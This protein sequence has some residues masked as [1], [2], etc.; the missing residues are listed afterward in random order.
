V[1]LIVESKE[2]EVEI[3][4]CILGG[5]RVHVDAELT[6]RNSIIDA[7]EDGI[8]YADDDGAG[9]GGE[10]RL[11]ECTVLGRVHA[12]TIQ[13]VSNSI[14][15][16]RVPEDETAQWPGPVLA[17]RKQAGCI[18]FSWLPAGSRTPRRHRCQP[19]RDADAAWL[20]PVL[21]SSR[22][23]DPGYCQLDR[24]TPGEIRRGADDEAEM[25]V[26]HDLYQPQREDYLSV[27][28]EEYLRFGLESGIFFET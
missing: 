12:R 6:A 5:L 8:A 17:D 4:S 22:Y 3:E 7:G 16:A 26:F 23:A 2:T 24:R 15:L 21:T 9:G 27:R 25:G 10:L 13:L 28:L 18:R 14:L 19:E 20:R 11:E 1:S